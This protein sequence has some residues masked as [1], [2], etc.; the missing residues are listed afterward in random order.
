VGRLVRECVLP[1]C[2]ERSLGFM[3]A[4]GGEPVDR[5]SMLWES[6]PGVKFVLFPGREEH[7]LP[8]TVSAFNS[9]NVLLAGPDQPLSYPRALDSFTGLRLETLGSMFHA[10]HSGASVAEG[11]VGSWAHLRWTLGRALI[12]H[13]SELWR[14]GWRY[15]DTDVAR[16]AAAVLGGNAAAF[17][18][19]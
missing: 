1:L 2:A 15:A 13:Y 18:G 3:L 10:C 4:A 6:F 7:F 5:L 16:D 12:R 11:L 19:L 17:L 9:R 8:A 14:T